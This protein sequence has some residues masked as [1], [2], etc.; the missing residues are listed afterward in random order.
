MPKMEPS[1]LDVMATFC[2]ESGS[3]SL[4]CGD[5]KYTSSWALQRCAPSYPMITSELSLCSDKG[6]LALAWPVCQS[7]QINPQLLTEQIKAYTTCFS[8]TEPGLALSELYTT[9][10]SFNANRSSRSKSSNT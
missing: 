4:G 5:V 8:H 3:L 9:L 10:F 1:S 2:Q 6:G 7:R